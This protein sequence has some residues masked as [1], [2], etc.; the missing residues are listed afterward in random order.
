MSKDVVELGVGIDTAR[1]GHH[2][3]VLDASKHEVEKPFRFRED[4]KGYQLVQQLLDR[5]V[6]KYGN[7]HFRVH[8]DAA[9]QYANNLLRWLQQL[10]YSMTV[11]V[12]QPARNKAYRA[13]HFDKRKAD[14]SESKAC[15]R[16]AIVERPAATAQIPLAFLQLQTLLSQLAAI[17]RQQTRLVNQLHRNLTE[18]FPEYALVVKHLDAQWS[19]SLLEKYPSPRKLARARL[20]SLLEIPYLTQDVAEQLQASAKATIAFQQGD[21]AEQLIVLK[22]RE[23]RQAQTSRSYLESLLESTWKSLPDGP[24]RRVLTIKGIGLLTACALVGKIVSIDRFETA[25]QLVGYFGIFPE[26]VDVSGV[27]RD[28][29]PKS[30]SQHHMSRKG[31]D[32]VR[33]LLYTAAQVAVRHNPA[34]HALYARLAARG[35]PYSV[36]LGHCMAKLLR[37]VFGV[38]KS[39]TDFDPAHEDAPET[40]SPALEEK[41]VGHKVEHL[42]PQPVV[43][44]T[45]SSLASASADDKKLPPLDFRV[46]R[47]Q[48]TMQAVLAQ[49]RWQPTWKRGA[50][51]RGPCPFESPDN[52]NPRIFTVQTEKNVYCCHGCGRQG[53]VIHLWQQHCGKNEHEAGWDLVHTFHLTPPLL[54]KK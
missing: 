12:G 15:A 19:L 31:N 24:H 46:I 54:K 20:A 48:V 6:R 44:T 13:V 17:A 4:A 14:A 30:G 51:W 32:Q 37:Q 2:L 49:L 28:G 41:V 22:V 33:R 11:T 53:D 16:F 3:T 9:G 40:A 1:Y 26:E 8:V 52:T 39:D 29:H 50:Q 25:A 34:V 35:K 38:W 10:D 45:P 18:S 27:D 43:T 5:L 47:Q 36:I 21:V 23:I 7:V 42:P